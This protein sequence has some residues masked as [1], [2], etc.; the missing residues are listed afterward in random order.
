[1]PFA[2]G[3]FSSFGHD[4]THIG[5]NAGLYGGY[6]FNHILSAELSLRWGQ[7]NLSARDCCVNTL[8]WL[9]SDG[10]R[11][12]APVAGMTGWNYEDLKSNVGTQQYGARLNINVLG[13]FAST[14]TSRWRLE[15][16]PAVYALATKA[17]IKTLADDNKVMVGDRKWHLAYGGRIQA[18]Y[19]ITDHLGVGIYSEFAA[20]TGSRLDGITEHYHDN[21]YIWESGLRVG[22]SFGKA[23]KPVVEPLPAEPA[24]ATPAEPEQPVVIVEEVVSDT[25]QVVETPAPAIVF[26]TIYFEFNSSQIA[27]SEQ[28]KLETIAHLLKEHGD[29]QVQL[30]GWCDNSG[31]DAVNDRISQQ[32]ADAVKA[33][34]VDLGIDA[35]RIAAIGHGID[36]AEPDAAKARR[37]AVSQPEQK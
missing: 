33:R 13:F 12:L 8:F 18:G 32:R 27:Q 16:A 1:M 35:S 31:S 17:D 7:T 36:L 5:Y 15:V 22:W 4:K 23:T 10:N 9:G 34:L 25:V 29:M 24:P 20:L 28:P 11:Y 19:M 21:N 26:P 3:S 2:F 30:N 37:V 6:R 14:K